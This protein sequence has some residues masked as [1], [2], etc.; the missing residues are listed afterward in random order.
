MKIYLYK[1][2]KFRC[3]YVIYSYIAIIGSTFFTR[4]KLFLTISN[5]VPVHVRSLSM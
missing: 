5:M 1:K 4:N 2:K 3:Q